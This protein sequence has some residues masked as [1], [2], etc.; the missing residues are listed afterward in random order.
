M[1][2]GIEE[3]KHDLGWPPFEATLS[4]HYVT[5]CAAPAVSASCGLLRLEV[6]QHLGVEV[7]A[8]GVAPPAAHA[9]CDRIRSDIFLTNYAWVFGCHFLKSVYG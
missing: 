6:L 9:A 5:P 7:R 4:G 2:L 3:P 8:G 1:G